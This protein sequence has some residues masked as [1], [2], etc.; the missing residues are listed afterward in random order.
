MAAVRIVAEGLTGAEG[1]HR[2]ERLGLAEAAK[3][4]DEVGMPLG[5]AELAVGGGLEPGFLLHPDRG[6]DSFVFGLAE[7]VRGD[8]AGRM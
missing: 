1:V 7:L 6:P 4:P 8:D 5:P 3:L 2:P